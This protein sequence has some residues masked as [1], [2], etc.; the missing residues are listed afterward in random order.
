MGMGTVVYDV[1]VAGGIR[2]GF[3]SLQAYI[4]HSSRMIAFTTIMFVIRLDRASMWR[5][6]YFVHQLAVGMTTV[7]RRSRGVSAE[8][9]IVPVAS[10]STCATEQADNFIA[11]MIYSALSGSQ[12]T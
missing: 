11:G 6:R 3:L 12:H 7:E 2:P 8:E 5:E 4:L 10:I 9:M 1:L